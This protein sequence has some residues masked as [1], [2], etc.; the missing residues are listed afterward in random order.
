MR[1]AA[2]FLTQQYLA[3]S[4]PIEQM[5]KLR[6]TETVLCLGHSSHERGAGRAF[7]HSHV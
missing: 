7:L 5:E 3:E 2:F 4:A 6:L 1:H